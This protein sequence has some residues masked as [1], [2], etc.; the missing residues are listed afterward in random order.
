MTIRVHIVTYHVIEVDHYDDIYREVADHL[1]RISE[2]GGL[3]SS[4]THLGDL[5]VEL[6]AGFKIEV[7]IDG[8]PEAAHRQVAWAGCDNDS[9]RPVGLDRG[10]AIALATQGIQAAAE[11][12][13]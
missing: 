9:G 12:G 3:V 5:P 6:E 10:E 2:Y 7:R 4:A 1:D 11:M 8:D 13:R